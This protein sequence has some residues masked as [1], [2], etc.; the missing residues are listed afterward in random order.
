MKICNFIDKI[1][2]WINNHPFE[3][4]S[5]IIVLIITLKK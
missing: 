3:I 1:G 2:D 5:I 4:I